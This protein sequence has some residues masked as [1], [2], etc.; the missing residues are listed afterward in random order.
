MV[1]EALK[2]GG[3]FGSLVPTV[4][5]VSNLLESLY[6]HDFS[7]I[8]VC[9]ILLRYYKTIPARLRPDDRMT[10]HTGFLIFARPLLTKKQVS[11]LNERGEE[12]VEE[13]QQFAV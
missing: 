10:A 7:D 12:C 13:D 8:E 5:Q 1:R 2:P 4:N 9:E 6:A 3:Y 11:D